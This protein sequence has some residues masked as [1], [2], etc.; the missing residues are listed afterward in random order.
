MTHPAI[1]TQDLTKRFGPIVAVDALNLWVERGEVFGLLGPNG[2]GKTTTVRMLCGIL[3]PS[4][5]EARVAGFPIS[6]RLTVAQVTGLLP[7]T[8]G[9]YDRLSVFRNLEIFAEIYR[10]PD[11]VTKI[12]RYLRL[13][14]LWDHRDHPAGS[15]SKGMR[16]KVALARA[17]VHDPQILFLDEPTASL[18][19]LS[20]KLI[21]ELIVNLKAR[22]RTVVICTHNLFEAEQICDRVGILTKGKL[23]A[24]GAPLEIKEHMSRREIA[25]TLAGL[26]ESLLEVLRFDFIK[27]KRR[28]GNRLILD[29]D[30]P[31][32][33]IPQVVN[34]L[35]RAGGEIIFITEQGPSLEQVYLELT[36]EE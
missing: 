9:L 17:L 24:V 6:D 18:D 19:P 16:Q 3:W 22:E 11:R 31:E 1:E 2:A 12:N 35:V 32:K 10:V 7:E 34:A 36:R 14:D 26:D 21:R 33:E 15:L 20:A 27:G 8:P 29:L 4:A 30:H 25:V 23:A 5:G 13:F 28:N